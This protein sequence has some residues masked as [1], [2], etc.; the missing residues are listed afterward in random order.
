MHDSIWQTIASTSWWVL[1]LFFY[2]MYVS[3]AAT[4]PK[5]IP[6]R[7]FYLTPPL[8]I[9]GTI[10]GMITLLQT[11]ATNLACWAVMLVMGYGLGWLQFNI[12]KVKANED[13]KLLLIPGTKSMFFFVLLGFALKIYLGYEISFNLD[14]FKTPSYSLA[15]MIMYGLF[16]GLL[17]GRMMYAKRAAKFGPFASAT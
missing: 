13:G 8:F 7:S 10:A 4:K 6:V 17:L 11:N 5:S 1:A 14:L 16:T 15:I 3:Y 2:L 9:M 12:M